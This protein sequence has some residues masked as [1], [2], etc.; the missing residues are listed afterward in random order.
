M[1][2]E[3]FTLPKEWLVPLFSSDTSNM[4]DEDELQL[5]AFVDS[6]IQKGCMFHAISEGEDMGFMKY[7]DA[8][9]YGALATDCV[10]VVFDVSPIK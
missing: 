6:N 1:K 7:H 3:T 5:D 2:T 9:Q 4:S 8:E 10:E